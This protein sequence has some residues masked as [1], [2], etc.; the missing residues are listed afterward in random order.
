MLEYS[1]EYPQTNEWGVSDIYK[2]KSSIIRDVNVI[3][4]FGGDLLQQ[5]C[6]SCKGV[7]F[8]VIVGV[9]YTVFS[10]GVVPV[11]IGVGRSQSDA[12]VYGDVHIVDR[13]SQ[14]PR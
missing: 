1:G 10:A 4:Y 3:S 6:Y 8:I 7:I 13:S 2:R 5:F 11:I 9:N 12:I 14:A